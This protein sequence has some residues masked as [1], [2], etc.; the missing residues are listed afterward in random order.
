MTTDPKNHPCTHIGLAHS[1]IG[2][3]VVCQEC[4]VVHLDLQFMSLRLNLEAFQELA[5]ML[6]GA[7][8]HLEQLPSP[9]RT[10]QT[11][12]SDTSNACPLH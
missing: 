8:I 6:A 11:R 1:S 4:G 7:Q 5:H 12:R 3:V 9:A 10:T 2:K